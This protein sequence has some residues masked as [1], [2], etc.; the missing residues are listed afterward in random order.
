MFNLFLSPHFILIFSFNIL[1]TFVSS[2]LISC[3]YNSSSD[4]IMR[5]AELLGNK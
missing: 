4:R 1:F 3:C 5:Y 2:L